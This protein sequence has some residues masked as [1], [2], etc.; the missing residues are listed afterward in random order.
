MFTKICYK[1]VKNVFTKLWVEH[2]INYKT[3]STE[4]RGKTRKMLIT[5][6]NYEM[7][8]NKDCFEHL[9]ESRKQQRKLVTWK[10]DS[11]Y[12]D[13]ETGEIINKIRL[14]NGEYIKIKSNSKIK[15]NENGNKSKTI[16]TECRENQS[17]LFQQ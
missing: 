12:V 5:L 17:R 15:T 7:G 9:R 8:Y 14:K 2:S 11:I 6:K 10:T 1:F 4:Q 3:N 16:T 13:V